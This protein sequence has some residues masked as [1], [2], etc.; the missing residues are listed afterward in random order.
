MELI[1][2]RK[3]G[4]KP[5][6]S[7]IEEEKIAKYIMEMARYGHSINITELKIKLRRLCNYKR[8]FLRMEF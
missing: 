3:R 2:S 5:V 1:L 6:L 7:P 8:L 4:R